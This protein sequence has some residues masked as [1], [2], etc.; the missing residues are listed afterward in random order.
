MSDLLKGDQTKFLVGVICGFVLATLTLSHSSVCGPMQI[1]IAADAQ[2]PRQY[3]RL[4]GEASTPAA[5]TVRGATALPSTAAAAPSG[6]K[7]LTASPPLPT[8]AE[9]AKVAVPTSISPLP[10]FLHFGADGVWGHLLDAPNGLRGLVVEVGSFDGTQ[11]K[12]AAKRGFQTIVFEPSPGNIKLVNKELKQHLGAS[13]GLVTVIQVAASAKRGVASFFANKQHSTGDHITLDGKINSGEEKHYNDDKA[14]K[15]SVPTCPVDDVLAGKKVYILKVDVQGH[16]WHVLQG[17]QKLFKEQRV[18]FAIFE[19]HPKRLKD[20]APLIIETLNQHGY[21]VH[22]LSPMWARQQGKII[23]TDEWLRFPQDPSAFSKSFKDD[24]LDGMG[25][26]TDILAVCRRC[27]GDMMLPRQTRQQ[28]EQDV[29]DSIFKDAGLEPPAINYGGPA[30]GQEE[31]TQPPP[32]NRP[33]R[34]V[35]PHQIPGRWR[36]AGKADEGEAP[37]QSEGRRTR[38]PPEDNMDNA[39]PRKHLSPDR[40]D[41]DAPRPAAPTTAVPVEVREVSED[42]GKGAENT[43]PKRKRAVFDDDV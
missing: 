13:D 3:Q 40:G 12:M 36:P 18:A 33:P 8:I 7:E 15:V 26:W 31:D 4:S 35:P 21:D 39:A 14:R 5:S 22:Y 20:S 30:K 42:G 17:A 29:V 23:F 6:E 16:E 32:P 24:F 25:E 41:A 28:V 1:A 37:P 11:A 10:A 27:V 19:F 43:R 34:V 9:G 2:K 38:A